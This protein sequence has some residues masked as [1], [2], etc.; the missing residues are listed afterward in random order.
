M[1]KEDGFFNRMRVAIAG[2]GGK[3]A[4]EEQARFEAGVHHSQTPPRERS[5]SGGSSVSASSTPS[6]KPKG[7][8]K[9]QGR[10]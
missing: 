9:G 8:V 3:K 10:G 5:G 6:V 1:S 4:R 2:D 7:Q